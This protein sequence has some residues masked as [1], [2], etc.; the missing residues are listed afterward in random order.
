MLSHDEHIPRPNKD[1]VSLYKAFLLNIYSGQVPVKHLYVD[2]FLICVWVDVSQ[3]LALLA[4][5]SYVL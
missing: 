4:F 1:D 3:S 2:S 5:V